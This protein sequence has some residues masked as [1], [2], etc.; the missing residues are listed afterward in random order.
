[1]HELEAKAWLWPIRA[2][3]DPLVVRRPRTWLLTEGWKLAGTI[4]ARDMP[5]KLR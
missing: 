3:Y 2:T 4:S 1:M 5:S